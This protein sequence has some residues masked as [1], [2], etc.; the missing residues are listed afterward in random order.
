MVN[1]TGKR[2]LCQIVLLLCV[3]VK[4]PISMAQGVEIIDLRHRSVEHLIPLLTPM[5]G[6]RA[7]LTG[8]GFTLI[9]RGDAVAVRQV[10]QAL[11]ILDTPL[12]RLMISVRQIEDGQRSKVEISAGAVLRPGNSVITGTAQARD[13]ARQDQVDQRIQGL[14]GVPAFIAT[15][16]QRL[17]PGAVV[18][19]NPG[20]ASII[21]P[22]LQPVEANTGFYVLARVRSQDVQLELSTQ[23]E[24]FDVSGQIRRS[25][26][27][28]LVAGRLGEWIDLGATEVETRSSGSSWL[29]TNRN[30]DEKRWRLQIRVEEIK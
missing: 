30:A 23:K 10:R 19:V 28:T 24:A 14:E 16:E 17:I 5:V 2:Y 25:A 3:A 12:R 18:T 4:A 6:E 11:E 9:V 27:V 8:R 1:L 22:V 7:A 20:G 15:G 29:G 26:T 21:N 13:L